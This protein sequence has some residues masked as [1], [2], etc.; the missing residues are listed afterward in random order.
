MKSNVS[1]LTEYARMACYSSLL[2]RGTGPQV[3]LVVSNQMNMP[4]LSNASGFLSLFLVILEASL[5][6]LHSC[7]LA[8]R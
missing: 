7:A 3:K 8:Q 1:E 4:T 6:S 2:R 5:L